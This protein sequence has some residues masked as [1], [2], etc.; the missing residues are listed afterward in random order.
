MAAVRFSHRLV[1]D[2]TLG[3]E[4]TDIV[5]QILSRWYESV[6]TKPPSTRNEGVCGSKVTALFILDLDNKRR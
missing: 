4:H 3:S 5:T 6:K 2:A 1:S